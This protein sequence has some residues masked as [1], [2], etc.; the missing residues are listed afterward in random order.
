MTKKGQEVGPAQ[1][2]TKTYYP[3]MVINHNNIDRKT[4]EGTTRTNIR[5]RDI[6]VHIIHL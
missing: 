4:T 1:A 3:T 5:L 6:H 2:N